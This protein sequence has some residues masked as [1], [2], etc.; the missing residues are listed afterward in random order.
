MNKE[1]I[2][3]KLLKYFVVTAD[4]LSFTSAS[5]Q[6][7]IPKSALSKGIAKLET[8]LGAKL[9][10]RSS[11]VVHLTET[12][13]ILYSRATSLLDEANHLISDIKTMQLSVAGQLK[14][15][16]PPAL[17]RFLAKNIIPQFLAHWPDV[18][19]SLK[20]SYEYENLFK[21]GLD[22]AF[23]FGTNRDDKL[24]E[25]PLGYSNRVIVASP[26]YLSKH[27]KITEPQDLLSHKSVQFFEQAQQVWRLQDG[28]TTE[29][30]S[31]PV[32][33]QCADL[34]AIVNAT[35][36]GLG[37]AKLPWLLVRDEI[38]SGQLVHVLPAWTSSGLSISQVYRQ[39][40]NKPA[41]LAEFLRWLDMHKSL[42]DLRFHPK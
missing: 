21:E 29:Q 18:S 9:F 20:L 39:G 41:K 32:V 42:F 14:L 31:L 4:T 33:F 2:D 15:A 8:E 6:L 10:E 38:Q 37:V 34:A 16:A 11:R 23:R 1:T 24:I 35:I 28:Q 25:K 7:D 27:K 36:E 22:L 26:D 3:L 5:H 17:G 30:I 40:H 12:G 19:I 13:Q